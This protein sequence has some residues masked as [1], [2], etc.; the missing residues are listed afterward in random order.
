VTVGTHSA[1]EVFH[2]GN[3]DGIYTAVA[4]G[5]GT[6]VDLVGLKAQLLPSIEAVV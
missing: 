6:T 1:Y 4:H 5:T 2:D 3:G